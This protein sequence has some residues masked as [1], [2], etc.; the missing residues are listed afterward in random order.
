MKMHSKSSMRKQPPSEA[1]IDVRYLKAEY[2]NS[3]NLGST[4]E[5]DWDGV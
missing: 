2:V 3:E 1:N 5:M 4:M